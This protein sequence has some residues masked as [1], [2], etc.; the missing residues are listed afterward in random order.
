MWVLVIPST[1]F[2]CCYDSYEQAM[3][4]AIG[5][6]HCER[7]IWCNGQLAAHLGPGNMRY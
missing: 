5:F 4:V 2:N 3:A 7:L 6:N 1:G